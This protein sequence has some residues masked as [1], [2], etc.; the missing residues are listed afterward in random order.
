MGVSG[1]VLSDQISCQNIPEIK[2]V[3]FIFLWFQ[4]GEKTPK[5]WPS[6]DK[7]LYYLLIY[8]PRCIYHYNEDVFDFNFLFPSSFQPVWIHINMV[9]KRSC[10]LTAS[11]CLLVNL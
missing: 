4:N 7:T 10:Q 9:T 2:S 6:T 11:L 3:I 8:S 5:N 1:S